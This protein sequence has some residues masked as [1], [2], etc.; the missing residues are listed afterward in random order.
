MSCVRRAALDPYLEEARDIVETLP[1]AD[2]QPLKAAATV[3]A[4]TTILA[5]HGWQR[6]RRQA[7]STATPG[8]L[9]VATYIAPARP[10]FRLAGIAIRPSRL[11]NSACALPTIW[12]VSSRSDAPVRAMLTYNAQ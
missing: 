11:C 4:G 2:D 9:A 8:C 12:N 7:W 5:A 6:R 10:F 3:R 1:F